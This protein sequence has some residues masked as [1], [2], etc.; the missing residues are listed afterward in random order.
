MRVLVTG[1][2]GFVGSAISANL[3]LK[4]HEVLGIDNFTDYYS[5]DLKKARVKNFLTA[6][7]IDCLN[8]DLANS[9]TLKKTLEEFLPETVIHLG[10]QAGVRLPL[11]EMWRYS[12]SNLEGFT[13]ILEIA[14]SNGVKNF[15][16]AS[17]SSVYGNVSPV[18]YSEANNL[19]KP[20]S[21]YGATKLFNELATPTLIKDSNT[22]A[23]G[24]RFFTVYGPWGRPDMAYFRM[25]SN[26]VAKSDFEFF[27]DGTIER[28]F[29]YIDDANQ[30]VIDLMDE[31]N[32][33]DPGFSDV[34]NV[35]GGRPLSM[36]YLSEL[37]E[38]IT[39][40]KIASRRSASKPEDVQKT[41]A[42]PRYLLQLIG[43]K[44]ETKLEEGIQKTIEWCQGESRQ[45]LMEWVISS[46]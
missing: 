12:T 46:K 14:V 31:L 3:H 17:S 45:D 32:F 23:R 2:A 13:N 8:V 28:D 25:I 4:G 37:I 36:N 7:G 10:A 21:F 24:L 5:I 30:I 43:N 42:D 33:R 6:S 38:N 26:I 9:K 27:G 1:A 18:P 34:V 22:R 41:M 44:P 39:G 11:S 40:E 16:Y 35:G 29:T 20:N 19:L 15:L